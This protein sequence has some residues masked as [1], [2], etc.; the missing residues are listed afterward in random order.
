MFPAPQLK[1]QELWLRTV[2]VG[3]ER[4]QVKSNPEK[5]FN[6]P[7]VIWSPRLLRFAEQTSFKPVR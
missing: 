4:A 1:Q 7:A 6:L 2:T 3:R 5:S